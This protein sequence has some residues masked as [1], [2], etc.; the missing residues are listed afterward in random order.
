MLELKVNQNLE[1]FPKITH[2][3]FYLKITFCTIASNITKYL[4][5]FCK[6]IATNFQKS[7]NLVTLAVMYISGL[8]VPPDCRLRGNHG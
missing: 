1:K 3:S 8:K 5:Y 6:K 2:N 7:P 4:G